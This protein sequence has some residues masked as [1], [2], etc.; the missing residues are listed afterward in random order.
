MSK[1]IQKKRTRSSSHGLEKR[2]EVLYL[3]TTTTIPM[4]MGTLKQVDQGGRWNTSM[5]KRGD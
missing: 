3:D 2:K 4:G 1:N 5:T